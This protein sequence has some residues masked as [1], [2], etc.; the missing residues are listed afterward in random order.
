MARVMTGKFFSSL[1][2]RSSSR[3]PDQW[4]LMQTVVAMASLP[5]AGYGISRHADSVA[6]TEESS[7]TAFGSFSTVV[8]NSPR[9]PGLSSSGL[10]SEVANSSAIWRT[11][12]IAEVPVFWAHAMTSAAKAGTKVRSV[13]NSSWIAGP[14]LHCF[15]RAS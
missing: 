8:R 5:A 7:R 9:A 6:E 4:R 15:E 13:A 2:F 12:P 10:S 11:T 14:A 1:I 3:K